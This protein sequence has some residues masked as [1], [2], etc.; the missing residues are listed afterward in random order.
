MAMSV[1]SIK[2]GGIDVYMRL[3]TRTFTIVPALL[4]CISWT[5]PAP[6]QTTD[7]AQPDNTKTNKRDRSPGAVTADQQKM[8][9]ADRELSKKIRQAIIADKS[10]STYAHNVKIVS[11]DGIVTLKGPVHSDAEKTTIEA[12]AAEVAGA[13]KVKSEISVKQ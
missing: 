13:D 3:S 2:R 4:L 6:A 10:L 8:N 12:K 5:A 7:A 9:S 1:L 11:Q